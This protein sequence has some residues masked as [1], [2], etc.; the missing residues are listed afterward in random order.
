M[1]E[2]LAAQKDAAEREKRSTQAFNVLQAEKNKTQK[3]L[4]EVKV[5]HAK[6]SEDHTA[7]IKHHDI[8]IGTAKRSIATADN[9]RTALQRKIEDLTSQNQ[10]LARA[11][12]SSQRAKMME[13]DSILNRS[14][15]EFDNAGDD[16]T[17][18]HS[19]PQ[20]PM[21]GTTPRH[22][23]L[24][25][26][27][28]KTSLQHAQRTIQSH[29]NQVHREKTE[30][31]ELRRMLQEARDEVERLR[32]EAEAPVPRRGKKS[33]A[34]E[35]KKYSKLL[36]G[37]S[38][39]TRE[40]IYS[41]DDEEWEDHHEPPRLFGSVSSGSPPQA[42]EGPPTDHFETANEATDGAFETANERGTET[43][44][45][46]TGAEEF[47]GTE[48]DVTETDTPTKGPRRTRSN[49][50]ATNFRKHTARRSFD[51]TAS[52]SNDED[53]YADA[54]VPGSA[55]PRMK[56][57]VSRGGLLR[58]GRHA[59][60]E[61]V[62]M[63]GSPASF[64][65][66]SADGT[67][68]TGGQS[69]FAELGELDGS[70]DESF[71]EGTPSRTLFGSNAS[72]SSTLRTIPSIQKFGMVG[73]PAMADPS[74]PGSEGTAAIPTVPRPEMVDSG[75]M[76]ENIEQPAP[77]ALATEAPTTEDTEDDVSRRISTYSDSGAQYDPEIEESLS[78]FPV[79]P[80]GEKPSLP[81]LEF[82]S[83]ETQHVTPVEVPEVAP[84]ALTLS[85]IQREEL[86][87]KA[88]PVVAPPVPE[89]SVS[90]IKAE[91]LEPRAEP[92][93]VPAPLS[94]SSIHVEALDPRAEPEPVPAPL[95]MSDIRAEA[96]D[97]RAEPE[98]VPA[99][100]SLSSIRAEALDPRAEPELPRPDLTVSKVH[101]QA[102]EPDDTPLDT[103][104]AVL[105]L[106]GSGA[107]SHAAGA[108]A[109][110]TGLG[111]AA[112]G[113]HAVD[114]ETESDVAQPASAQSMAA[115]QS[116]TVEPQVEREA[117]PE[118][119]MT[120]INAQDL[121]P[122]AEP[123]FVPE[124]GI[125]AISSQSWEPVVEPE[126]V[127]DLGMAAINSQSC[128]PVAEPEV[129]PELSMAGISSQGYEPVA[130]EVVL[131]EL[132]MV[133]IN[134]QELEPIAEP[135]PPA[136]E[137]IVLG[138]SNVSSEHIHPVEETKPAPPLLT[139]STIRAE[140]V[141]P[142]KSPS[143]LDPRPD[144]G[145]TTIQSLE[146]RP[147]SPRSPKRDAFIL[148]RD[149]QPP[150]ADP[151]KLRSGFVPESVLDWD[152]HRS[153]T[154][155]LIAEDETRQ[156]P[157]QSPQ[158]ETPESQRPLQAMSANS[159]M[160]TRKPRN[161]TLDSG[162]QTALT[163]DILDQMM[164]SRQNQL[165]LGHERT[166]SIE[167]GLGG[168][169]PRMRRGST[170][171]SGSVVRHRGRGLDSAM[172]FHRPMSASSS[173]APTEDLPPLPANH[174]Q[175]IQAARTQSSDGQGSM[176]PPL[177]PASAVRSSRPS[178]PSILRSPPSVGSPTPRAAR[179]STATVLE[180]APSVPNLRS[181]QSS[182]TSFASELDSRFNMPGASAAM[183]PGGFGPNTDPRMIQAITQTMIGEFLW[184]YT[185]KT[186]RDEMSENRHRRYFWVHPYTRTLYWSER[187]PTT[188]GQR[189]EART[190]SIPIEAVR[191][192]TDDNPMPPGLPRKSLIVVSP[193]R[194]VKFTCTTNQRH[195]TWLNA[196]S[197][198]LMRTNQDGQSDAE[199]MAENITREDIDEFNPQVGRRPGPPTARH[200]QHASVSSFNSR[201]V[202]NESPAM[203]MSMNIPTLSPPKR[204][205]PAQP[206]GKGTLTRLSGY[207]K[208]SHAFSTLRTRRAAVTPEV[209]VNG[210]VH[211]SAEDVRKVMERQDQEADRLENVRA[212][213]DGKSLPYEHSYIFRTEANCEQVST[214]S[215]RSRAATATGRA[216]RTPTRAPPPGRPRA[217]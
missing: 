113:A 121:E 23:M 170:E 115:I 106:S 144:F 125:A 41:E 96:L 17:P 69:L 179:A 35:P 202:R 161:V 206:R 89:L 8:E 116:E 140:S 63:D 149:S 110:A 137:P 52:T 92:E 146:T 204:R 11:F 53:A 138:L 133:N 145:F 55:P 209:Y 162:A 5:S 44:D 54:D 28:L 100:L 131:P 45:F 50:T 94:I 14:D 168:P 126:V 49:L 114:R 200:R 18:E 38:R 76:T 1:Q 194:S 187:D 59:S 136:P 156:S 36:L 212:C 64:A 213:C 12:S 4:D 193:G 79:P 2:L 210:Q 160:R 58:H 56:L 197:Y 107:G 205:A 103:L 16:V 141:A 9:E 13:R 190:K 37:S 201:S 85:S 198:L 158:A 74:K 61:Q 6:L 129:V 185:R 97:P 99:P 3:E 73:S 123:E 39:P 153:A 26:E 51:S 191:V 75:T 164:R 139:A 217:Q 78:K 134:S 216:S 98:P 192:V 101:S 109:L 188:A 31:L 93:P 68:R 147:V 88:E 48:S 173:K 143:P 182:V 124:L 104:A 175:A 169:G 214:T 207:W 130:E 57:R 10:E 167:S 42:R 33:E 189:S 15:E 27:T 71:N 25:T 77:M 32:N 148:P 20:S 159:N 81:E 142:I 34:K 86:E 163:S 62:A 177:W 87:P 112:I 102:L 29:R 82:T 176:A 152:N 180:D 165:A 21:K 72:N 208:P 30:K 70:G 155:P 43:D 65:N 83:I 95:S 183:V 60:D 24:E 46:Q 7:A 91:V 154:P 119:S 211:D 19:P 111:A 171:S 157:G 132:K 90:G 66:S 67:P 196:L 47:S 199:L 40:D 203:D 151:H 181:R 118:L 105:G 80:L 150:V 108:A 184:K 178:T 120:T 22:S 122:V 215:V 174:R 166:R 117:V 127:P 128:E 172:E 135:E 195:E 186:G 84:P